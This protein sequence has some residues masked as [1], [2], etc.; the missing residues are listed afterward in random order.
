[1]KIII[2]CNKVV[3]AIINSTGKT[4]EILLKKSSKIEFIAPH[5]LY[6]E[7]IDKQDKILKITG[8][9]G[10]EFFDLLYILIKK[11]DF[12]DEELIS[13][14]QRNKAYELTKDIDEKDT[15]YIALSIYTNS[16]IWT[17]DKKLIKGLKNKGF[18]NFIDTEK[19][20]N[21]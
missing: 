6:L 15:P 13:S 17:G 14:D 12:I 21:I 16:R 3:S 9:S 11:I 1:M 5:Y 8:Y 18:D 4:S 10:E 7:L 20:E 2:D 19:I